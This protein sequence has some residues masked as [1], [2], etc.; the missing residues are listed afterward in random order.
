MEKPETE[1]LGRKVTPYDTGKVKIGLYYEPPRPMPEDDELLLQH[2]LLRP[3]DAPFREPL[4]PRIM[5]ALP[6][7]VLFALGFSLY[8]FILSRG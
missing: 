6:T 7:I 8:V 1:S 3:S 5:R 4:L 2:A